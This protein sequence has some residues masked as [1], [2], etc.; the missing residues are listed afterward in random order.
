MSRRLYEPADEEPGAAPGAVRVEMHIYGGGVF[1]AQRQ[2]MSINIGARNADDPIS[3]D[4]LIEMNEDRAV[5]TFLAVPSAAHILSRQFGFIGE[6]I[7]CLVR[8]P[9]RV[10]VP[11]SPDGKPGDFDLIVGRI[12]D[13]WVDVSTLGLVEFKIAKTSSSP[14]ETTAAVPKYASGRGTKQVE[15]A[16]DLGFDYVLLAH[17]LVRDPN[18]LWDGTWA[19]AANAANFRRDTERVYG[20]L[21]QR[22]PD[23]G[24]GVV[25]IGWGQAAGANPR[26]TGAMTPT[27]L[28]Q[29]PRNN[30][31]H[32]H[33]AEIERQLRLL[34]PDRRSAAP[35]FRF[36]DRCDAAAV[37]DTQDP[38]VVRCPTHR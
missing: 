5:D 30:R 38:S 3:D 32:T 8:A 10:L 36:C 34:I 1:T 33:R 17:L 19:D 6:R 23:P 27:V 11:S 13:D 37:F 21:E 7:W 16:C 35:Y 15:T 14:H 4:E 18:A 28:W 12:V 29:T 25:V 31:R 26:F 24:Y 9:R 22:E 2:S 20:A